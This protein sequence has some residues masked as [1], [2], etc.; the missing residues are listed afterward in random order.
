MPVYPLPVSEFE[1]PTTCLSRA[2][3]VARAESTLLDGYDTSGVGPER[4]AIDLD[5]QRRSLFAQRLAERAIR[6]K[7]AADA[8]PLLC[9]EEKQEEEEPGESSSGMVWTG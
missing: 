5:I 2:W 1:P 8:R 9:A 7:R 6:A 4:A 3:F